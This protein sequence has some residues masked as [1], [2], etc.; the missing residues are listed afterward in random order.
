MA[1]SIS[2]TKAPDP[3]ADALAPAD[4][5]NEADDELCPPINSNRSW[6][7]ELTEPLALPAAPD[8][9]LAL[10]DAPPNDAPA[11]VENPLENDW[12]ANPPCEA[13]LKVYCSLKLIFKVF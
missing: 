9:A 8:E 2:L 13:P 1:A 3:T 12:D 10:N 7:I 5:E 4:A 11:P 6:A